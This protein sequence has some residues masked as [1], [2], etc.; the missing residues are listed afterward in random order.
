LLKKQGFDE[1]V[2]WFRKNGYHVKCEK[3][4]K[5]YYSYTTKKF[6]TIGNVWI[7]TISGKNIW[8]HFATSHCGF[9]T[10]YGNGALVADNNKVFN[11]WQQCPLL[12]RLPEALNNPEELLSNL[13]WL[14]SEEGYNHSNKFEFYDKRILPYDESVIR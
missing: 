5:S 2:R 6:K 8:G 14:A 1:A 3:K 13:A 11:K 12:V 9:R 10:L 7:A 4:T